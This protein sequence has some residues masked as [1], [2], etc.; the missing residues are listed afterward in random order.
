MKLVSFKIFTHN[1]NDWLLSE[2][3]DLKYSQ[4]I[5]GQ[6]ASSSLK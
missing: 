4:I 3:I 2:S 1:G 5:I 6:Y